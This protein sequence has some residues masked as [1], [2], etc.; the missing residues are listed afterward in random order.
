M[1][2]QEATHIATCMPPSVKYRCK[3]HDASYMMHTSAI[4]G[5]NLHDKSQ[6]GT[7]EKKVVLLY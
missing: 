2:L 4:A 7:E 6:R 3:Y 1:Q 5:L